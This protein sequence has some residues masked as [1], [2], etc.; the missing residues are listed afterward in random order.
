[1]ATNQWLICCHW[2]HFHRPAVS[3]IGN[4]LNSICGSTRQPPSAAHH[5]FDPGDKIPPPKAKAFINCLFRRPF[6]FCLPAVLV[7]VG[8]IFAIVNLIYSK[9]SISQQ[10]CSAGKRDRGRK[11][12]PAPLN[13]RRSLLFNVHSAVR[14]KTG[15]C[16]EIADS[17][18]LNRWGWLLQKKQKKKQQKKTTW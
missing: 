16:I 12:P 3:M 1:M 6:I 17:R 5:S 18:L 15:K 2:F 13:R 8:C 10:Y 11:T 4:M 9:F 7:K 14:S